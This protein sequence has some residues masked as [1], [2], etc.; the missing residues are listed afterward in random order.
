LR[1]PSRVEAVL[2]ARLVAIGRR[3]HDMHVAAD[4]N[5]ARHAGIVRVRSPTIA[6]E[7]P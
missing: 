3:R 7:T 1:G 6:N 5:R 2:C 4:A